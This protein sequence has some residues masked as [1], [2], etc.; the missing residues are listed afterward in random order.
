M[1][2]DS[3]NKINYGFFSLIKI[4]IIGVAAILVLSALGISLR[5]VAESEMARENFSFVGE[6]LD[7]IWHWLKVLIFDYLLRPIEFIWN[8]LNLDKIWL[9]LTS[10]FSNLKNGLK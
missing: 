5:S 8:S 6:I 2:G 4:I 9:N 7:N 10:F 1:A 3:D